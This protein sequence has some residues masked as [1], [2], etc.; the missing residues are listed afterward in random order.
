MP[1]EKLA[2]LSHRHFKIDM[3]HSEPPSRAPS[4]TSHGSWGW[5]GG[6][7]E[8]GVEGSGGG[9]GLLGGMCTSRRFCVCSLPTIGEYWVVRCWRSV[10]CQSKCLCPPP[11]LTL[12]L[13][14]TTTMTERA[15]SAC[16]MI[17]GGEEGGG[18]G[19]GVGELAWQHV[20]I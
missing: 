20:S 4:G 9:G 15:G 12:D 1:S 16:L 6:E 19:G 7:G 5:G 13:T 8:G 10:W 17:G 11:P 18:V 2:T 3:R 14:T